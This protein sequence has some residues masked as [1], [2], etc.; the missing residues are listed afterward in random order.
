MF[1]ISEGVLVMARE[2][3]ADTSR[4]K[5]SLPMSLATKPTEAFCDEAAKCVYNQ[6][7]M[8]GPGREPQ[9]PLNPPPDQGLGPT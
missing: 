9:M 6:S 2:G 5:R 4:R 1:S 7:L 3:K 8:M